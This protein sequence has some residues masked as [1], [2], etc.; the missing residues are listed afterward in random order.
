[1]ATR[2]G[3]GRTKACTGRPYLASVGLQGVLG[4]RHSARG[5]C[6]AAQGPAAS[7]REVAIAI[8]GRG[9]A[10]TLLQVL[11][12]SVLGAQAWM[13]SQPPLSAAGPL[14][15]SVFQGTLKP[16][17]AAAESSFSAAL[18]SPVACTPYLQSLLAQFQCGIRPHH[19]ALP[20]QKCVTTPTQ[21]DSSSEKPRPPPV[22]QH[23]ITGVS[24]P[25][26]TA[27]PNPFTLSGYL[28]T[29]RFPQISPLPGFFKNLGSEGSTS[30]GGGIPA[31]LQALLVPLTTPAS[32][33]GL[34][35]N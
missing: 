19:Q 24:L 9:K 15:L 14:G 26:G 2:E 18:L 10:Q 6:V 16:D 34:Q 4:T 1:M 29:P 20:L 32:L 35:V 8:A 21:A 23:R 11:V 25:P 33:P 3:A 7:N 30:E 27:E 12:H 22:G 5:S 31:P 17:Q 28:L 13:R